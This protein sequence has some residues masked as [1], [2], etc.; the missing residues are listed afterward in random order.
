MKN[1][2]DTFRQR[3]IIQKIVLA[4]TALVLLFLFFQN[5]ILSSSFDILMF[6][7]VDDFA[8]QH[9]L[10]KGH[11]NILHFKIDQLFKLYDYGYGWLFWITHIV[12]TFPFYLISL[13]GSDFLLISTARN[14]SL[15]FMAGGSFFLFRSVRKYTNDKYIPYFAVL[16]FISYPYFAYSA[17]SF[18]TIAQGSF[19]C[20]LTFYLTIRNDQLLKRD[21]K[22]IAISLAACLGT[23]LSTGLFAPL[24]ALFL[25]DRFGWKLNKENFKKAL[26]F[27]KYFIP[28]SIFFINPSLFASPFKWSLFTNY[29]DVMAGYLNSVQANHGSGDDFI[30]NFKGAFL[31]PFLFKYILIIVAI[32][33]LLKIF[34][35]LRDRK[36]QNR[37]DF[38]Y[39]FI[40]MIGSSLYLSNHIKMG[41]TYITNYFFSF[42][43]LLIFSVV[44]L[45]KL[46]NKLKLSILVALVTSNLF[47]NFP[48]IKNNYLDHH[49]RYKSDRTQTLIKSQK[50]LQ[51]LVGDPSQKLN[52]LI[53]HRA[54]VIYSNFKKNITITS[55]FDNISVMEKW[56]NPEYDYILLHRDSKAFLGDKEF[57]ENIKQADISFQERW[58]QSRKIIQSLIK[59]GQFRDSQYKKVYDKGK[60]LM[61]KRD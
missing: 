25:I 27:L 58:N 34:F 20:I 41:S 61:L 45:D 22:Y 38:L 54:P 24:I 44:I 28:S 19:F 13:L 59:T 5:F 33:F 11:E 49:N 16:L 15:L 30:L 23:K 46:N 35:D 51:E 39:I 18:R 32:L 40:F 8:F 43:F 9:T 57:Q 55:I 2:L 47:L 53:G 26:Y 4:T 42:S 37:F 36:K 60:L 48:A 14:I 6:R 21:L 52:L 17:M 12:I 10:R 56:N 3:N 31:T 50:E 7:G 1:L 29:R